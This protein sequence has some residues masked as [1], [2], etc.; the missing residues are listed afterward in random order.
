MTNL[1]SHGN[2]FHRWQTRLVS[3]CRGQQ[4]NP[5]LEMF[6]D[7]SKKE[8][9]VF[10]VPKPFLPKH[11]SFPVLRSCGRFENSWASPMKSDEFGPYPDHGAPVMSICHSPVEPALPPPKK[12]RG[13]YLVVD[14][15]DLHCVVVLILKG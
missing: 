11:I 13:A 6:D 12:N 2:S 4:S 15:T 10:R 14:R 1:I 5:T 9:H 8:F 7:F 3:V